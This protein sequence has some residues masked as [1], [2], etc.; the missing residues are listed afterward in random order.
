MVSGKP[1]LSRVMV[2]GKPS[3]SLPVAE[4]DFLADIGVAAVHKSF[5]V[6]PCG[7]AAAGPAGAGRRAQM[8]LAQPETPAEPQE[9]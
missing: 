4:F 9:G 5:R 2:S 1:S 8:A 6:D 3:L 7:T